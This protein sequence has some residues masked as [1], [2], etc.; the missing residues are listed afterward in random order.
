MRVGNIG[1]QPPMVSQRFIETTSDTYPVQEMETTSD[2]YT[3]QEM[4]IRVR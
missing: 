2:T 4:L 1:E 3:V